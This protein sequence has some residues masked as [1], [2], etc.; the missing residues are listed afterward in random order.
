MNGAS[1]STSSSSSTGTS[2]SSGGATDVDATEDPELAAAIQM[3]LQQEAQPKEPTP[4]PKKTI[5]HKE[6]FNK[7]DNPSSELGFSVQEVIYSLCMAPFCSPDGAHIFS[8][9]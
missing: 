1:S 5:E 9:R 4:R 8:C 7:R 2:S 3:S 6:P